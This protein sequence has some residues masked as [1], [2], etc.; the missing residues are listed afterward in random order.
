MS[1]RCQRISLTSQFD[2]GSHCAHFL[3]TKTIHEILIP[4]LVVIRSSGHGVMWLKW[5]CSLVVHVGSWAFGRLFGKIQT[6]LW[7]IQFHTRAFFCGAKMRKWGR[8]W[9]IVD[10]S[11]I[12]G[13]LGSPRRCD[14]G[15]GSKQRQ[16]GPPTRGEG[17]PRDSL[18]D[19]GRNL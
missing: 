3:S 7:S 12:P 11:V 17:E 18:M 2:H 5:S 19:S 15:Q 9:T 1:K 13:S 6:I 8:R 10:P 14:R 4:N 16:A